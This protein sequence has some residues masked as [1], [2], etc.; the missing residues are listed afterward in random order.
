MRWF[1][2]LRQQLSAAWFTIRLGFALSHF[3]IWFGVNQYLLGRVFLV[4]ACWLLLALLL[5]ANQLL[6]ARIPNS[7]TPDLKTIPISPAQQHKLTW[8]LL[9]LPQLAETCATLATA[10]AQH[11]THQSLLQN[12]ALCWLTQNHTEAAQNTWK[13]AQNRNPNH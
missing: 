13:Q 6:V 5:M 1:F 8:K 3:L 2:R 9:S 12:T 10:S 4:S 7:A 11:P